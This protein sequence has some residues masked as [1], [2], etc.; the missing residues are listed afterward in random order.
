MSHSDTDSVKTRAVLI[1]WCHVGK[2]QSLPMK[3]MSWKH[4]TLFLQ[5]VETSRWQTTL[6]LC[7]TCLTI[8][9]LWILFFRP[10]TVCFFNVHA[11]AKENIYTQQG[12]DQML[13]LGGFHQKEPHCLWCPENRCLI[14]THLP[15]QQANLIIL[16]KMFQQ[17]TERG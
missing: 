5:T 13:M 1:N 12:K 9:L 6:N 7:T 11:K 8:K 10:A 2:Y 16:A 15:H 4:A 3:F 14:F 17:K